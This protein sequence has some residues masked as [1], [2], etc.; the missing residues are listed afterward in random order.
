MQQML[1]YTRV[2]RTLAE[3]AVFGRGGGLGGGG[4]GHHQ[5]ARAHTPRS[6]YSGKRLQHIGSND[7]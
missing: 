3:A 4:G 6:P 5:E 1:R 7:P 2:Q